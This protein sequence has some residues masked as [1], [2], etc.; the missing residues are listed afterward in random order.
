[1]YDIMNRQAAS[2]PTKSFFETDFSLEIPRLARFSVNAFN[3][4]ETAAPARRVRKHPLGHHV[5]AD[6][7]AQRSSATCACCLVM[8]PGL[9][10][11]RLG[12]ATTLAGMVKPH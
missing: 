1:V 9:R 6:E 11:R 8:G 5:P 7:L 2:R 3:Q 10:G 4:P 12:K